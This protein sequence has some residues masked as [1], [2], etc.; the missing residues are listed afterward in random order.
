M[1]HNQDA[2]LP[3]TLLPRP[4]RSSHRLP[5]HI[6]EAGTLPQRPV[7]LIGLQFPLLLAASHKRDKRECRRGNGNTD[8]P[9]A[10]ILVFGEGREGPDQADAIEDG[11]AGT[12]QRIGVGRRR[13]AN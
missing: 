13:V 6:H 3:P 4:P 8:E 12:M 2:I 7:I 5:A 10:E 1:Y 9:A 11:M